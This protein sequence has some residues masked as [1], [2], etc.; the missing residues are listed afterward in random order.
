MYPG[1]AVKG[2]V[3][4][5]VFDG[6]STVAIASIAPEPSP[7][8]SESTQYRL[9]GMAVD[10]EYRRHRLATRLLA[11]IEL[12]L[13]QRQVPLLWFNARQVAFPFYESL[14]YEYAS[15]LFEMEEIG[16]HRV[17]YKRLR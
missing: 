8:F 12:C 6:Q 10:P 16:P 9:R 2:A 13:S 11:S 17:M 15:E 3:H 7:L 4:F 5:G 14:G 1:D